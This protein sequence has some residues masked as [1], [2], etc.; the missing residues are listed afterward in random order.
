MRSAPHGPLAAPHPAGSPSLSGL[1]G[2]SCPGQICFLPWKEE[3]TQ[4]YQN[5]WIPVRQQSF[6]LKDNYHFYPGV[7]ESRHLQAG[8]AA[9]RRSPG[10][11]GLLHHP[12]CRYLRED[13]HE[14]TNF[15]D[16]TSRG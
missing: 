13:R 1:R 4:Y 6:G 10:T 16:S 5:N 2:E 7:R 14:I 15:R 3:L 12:L 11:R 9:D 8:P